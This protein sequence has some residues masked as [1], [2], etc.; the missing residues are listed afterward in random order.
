MET[1]YCSAIKYLEDML[2]ELEVYKPP[3]DFVPSR[4]P[5]HLRA[6]LRHQCT[7]Y[8]YLLHEFYREIDDPHGAAW[9][10]SGWSIRV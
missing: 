2:A 7:N 3:P 6:Q 9:G 1:E 5:H 8:D 10:V 4:T